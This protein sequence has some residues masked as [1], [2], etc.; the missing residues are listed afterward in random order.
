[1]SKSVSPTDSESAGSISPL[2]VRNARVCSR[3]FAKLKEFQQNVIGAGFGLYGVDFPPA[4][5]KS[6][7]SDPI[8]FK[9][10]VNSKH[11]FF[12]GPA[13]VARLSVLWP[14]FRC[15]MYVKECEPL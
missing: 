4:G 7:S 6:K 13:G 12:C 9:M 5:S 10:E 14:D 15:C 3:F 11:A 2:R 8:P 1:M